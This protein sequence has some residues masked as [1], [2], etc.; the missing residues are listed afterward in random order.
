MPAELSLAA[1]TEALDQVRG[2]LRG[3]PAPAAFLTR[4]RSGVDAWETAIAALDAG[5]T[6]ADALTRVA[7]AFTM[8]EDF[9]D[10]TREAQEMTRLGVGTPAHHFLVALAPIR[11]DLVRASQRPLSQLRRAVSLERRAHSRWRGGEGRAAAL[12]DRDLE[13][14][15]VRVSA[16]VVVDQVIGLID[17]F[18][19][20]RAGT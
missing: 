11:R 1:L 9:A 8:D 16:K 20:W 6:A 18:T 4:L 12:V 17:T 7:T 3:D 10:P 14:E 5:G 15:E 2:P 19:R 13:L